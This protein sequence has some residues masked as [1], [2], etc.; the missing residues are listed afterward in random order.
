MRADM[1][2]W[3]RDQGEAYSFSA[4]E[5]LGG[6]LTVRASVCRGLGGVTPGVFPLMQVVT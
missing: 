2:T 1:I 4:D 5:L 3:K 6:Y